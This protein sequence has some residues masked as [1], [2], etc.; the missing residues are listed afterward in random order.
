MIDAFSTLS[1]EMPTPQPTT[2][3]LY[4]TIQ[5]TN[6]DEAQTKKV[7]III[8]PFPSLRSKNNNFFISV[9]IFQGRKRVPTTVLTPSKP[10]KR[11]KAPSIPKPKVFRVLAFHEVLKFSHPITYIVT[12]VPE[13]VPS[14]DS[15]DSDGSVHSH[16]FPTSKVSLATPPTP[17][18]KKEVQAKKPPS[19]IVPSTA[20]TPIPDDLTQV[21]AP[22]G[23]EIN[24]PASP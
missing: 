15:E 17:T 12:Q 22:Y 9:S 8:S 6:A 4:A 3:A 23:Q 19:I 10:S 2:D 14:V 5:I 16:I 11:Q 1:G 18:R 7:T 21:Y 13:E 24:T 20:K